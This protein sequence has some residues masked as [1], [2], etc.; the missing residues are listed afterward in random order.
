MSTLLQ[1]IP[2]AFRERVLYHKT[3]C[4][5]VCAAARRDEGQAVHWLERGRWSYRPVV[6]QAIQSAAPA[7]WCARQNR[8]VRIP[9]PDGALHATLRCGDGAGLR[10]PSN[11]QQPNLRLE[12]KTAAQLG[13]AGKQIVANRQQL[14]VE[15]GISNLPDLANRGRKPV[16]GLPTGKTRGG[17]PPRMVEDCADARCRV[18]QLALGKW[19]VDER[20]GRWIDAI[21]VERLVN[22]GH[23]RDITE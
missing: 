4:S 2:D 6:R 15:I 11:E 12:R 21:D 20:G 17:C 23:R 18:L 8:L 5:W 19:R 14:S 13:I 10:L 9:H 16:P 7:P 3:A 22:K 1:L